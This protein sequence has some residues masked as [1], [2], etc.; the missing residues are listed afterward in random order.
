MNEQN[1]IAQPAI[2]VT[3]TRALGAYGAAFDLPGPH[4]AFTYHHQPGNIGA[5]RLGAAWQKAASS[6]SGD[7]IDKGLGLLKAL[8][9][10]GFGVFEVSEIAAPVAEERAAR[11]TDVCKAGQADAV[12]CANDECDRANGVR[13]PMC[14]IP[15][16]REDVLRRAALASAPV[17]G[18]AVGVVQPNGNTF[19]LSRPLPAGTKVYAVP[20][21]SA[22]AGDDELVYLGATAP[23]VPAWLLKSARRIS[24]YMATHHPGEWAIYGI[25]IRREPKASAQGGISG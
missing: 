4:R 24:H 7:L 17:A 11:P 5:H 18:E 16:V 20:Q 6:S 13:P 8:L 14:R 21:A 2:V 10:V 12:L 1:K 19:R 22:E 3:L 9:E 25:Q 15:G 23:P